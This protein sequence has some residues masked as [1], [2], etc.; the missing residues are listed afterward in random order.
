M[1]K[2]HLGAAYYPE[3]WPLEEVDKDIARCKEYGLNT[4]RVGEFA[5]G[6]MEPKE[7][8]F[9]FEWLQIVL[10]KLY[11]AHISV[12]LCTPSCTPPRY[13]M[14]RYEEMRQVDGSGRRCEVSWR[15]H[16]CKTSPMMREKNRIIV[17]E[18][19]RRFGNHPA[20]I[21]WQIDNEFFPYN[22]QGCHCELCQHAF[23]DYLKERFKT[24]D[25]L[26]KAWG[27]SRW[28][29]DY[30]DFS[31]IRDPRPGEWV[32]PSLAKVWFDFQC[33]QIHT[34][35]L[36]QADVIRKYSKA[37]IG[38]DMMY[39]NNLPYS[40]TNKGLDLIQ[41]NHYKKADELHHMTFW[42]DFLRTLKPLPFFVTETQPN[43]SGSVFAENGDRP[44]G[45]T[46]L[47][48]LLPFLYGGEANL[49]WHFR[50][51][52]NGHE[53]A[54]GALFTVSGRP[55]VEM[56][57]I[58]RLSRDLEKLEPILSSKK[59]D[60]KIAIHYSYRAANSFEY[61]PMVKGFDYTGRLRD[62]FRD[63]FPHHNVDIIEKEH[64]VDGYETVFSPFLAYMSDEAF[65]SKMMDFVRSGGQWI[66]GPLSDIY[67][68]QVTQNIEAPYYNL[69][70]I[71]GVTSV[72]QKRV[73]SL[74][75]KGQG[76]ISLRFCYDALEPKEGTDSLLR[77]E[78]GEY[79]GYAAVTRRKV[80]KGEIILLGALP[81]KDY[82][83]SLVHV[84]PNAEGS[85]NV[86]VIKREDILIATEITHQNGT[87][88]L[89]GSY[90]D[91]LTNKTYEGTVQVEPYQVL[92]LTKI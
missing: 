17:E 60:S 59:L 87:L 56:K 88:I 22:D 48:S 70:S 83:A 13:M 18:M 4:L 26:N 76:G 79:Q 19:S 55:I 77:Y 42:Y 29:L 32:H 24:I 85:S 11:Q 58:A 91:V 75:I 31:T 16:P 34:Y 27:M 6:R 45:N 90:R 7:G 82:L 51:H 52:R 43:W 37:P 5:W 47:N 64:P 81:P 20:V 54:H 10:D 35:A 23:Q 61:A 38:T 69:E 89:N 67:D 41:V 73:D 68:D 21:A 8:V 80:G 40:E 1:K 30:E 78:T 3:L 28:S 39:N 36:E 14:N 84:K 15:V 9:D 63:A 72:Y 44:I 66:I 49:Y 71:C 65:L 86:R 25:A 50:A 53:L 12:I 2:Y 33:H 62:D 92:I 57:E 74:R 46:Y